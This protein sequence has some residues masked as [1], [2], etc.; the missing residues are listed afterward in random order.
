MIFVVVVFVVAIENLTVVS[1]NVVTLKITFFPLP[2]VFWGFLFL[3]IVFVSI[4]IV[5]SYLCARDRTEE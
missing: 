5:G 4:L 1:N 3:F 2:R